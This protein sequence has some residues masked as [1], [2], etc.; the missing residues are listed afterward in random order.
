MATERDRSSEQ[1]QP[2]ILQR[3]EQAI[4]EIHDSDSF[5]RYLDV[6]SRFHHYSPSNVAL[7]LSQRP[8]ATRV[9][10]YNAWLKMK[11]YVRKGEKAIK[12][13]V[14]MVKK[15]AD[16][17]TGEDI[18]R[19]RFG[20][21]NTFDIS[22]TEGEP[23]VEIHVPVLEGDEGADLYAKTWTYL[24]EA[25]IRVEAMSETEAVRQPS[26][27]GYFQPEGKLIRVRHDVSQLQRTKTL[28]HETAHYIGGHGE[29]TSLPRDEA[30]TEAESVAYVVAAHFGLDT[31]ERSFPYIA[32]WSQNRQTFKQVLG[33]IQ[34]TSARI[35][36]G[37][38][39][40]LAHPEA[41]LS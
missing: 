40:T 34:T 23:L 37:I 9:A 6:Q 41:E 17:E 33:K 22:S 11:R 2:E 13:I 15:D 18:R 5:R 24:T 38:E 31:G 30:E 8:D 32:I 10:G 28:L 19:L 20:I 27:M 14:P 21:G 29:C 3:L 35:I 26:L 16:A 7:I 39:G 12:I 25:G 4:G 1:R 36:D